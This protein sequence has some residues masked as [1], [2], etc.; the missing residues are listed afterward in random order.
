MNT[1]FDNAAEWITA[2]H[3]K[4]RISDM[5]TTHILNTLRM[6]ICKPHI[7]MTM[8]ITDIEKSVDN[9]ALETWHPYAKQ[10]KNCKK[11]SI[12][13]VTSMLPEEIMAYV[14]DSPLGKAMLAELNTR[15]VNIDNMISVWIKEAAECIS[16]APQKQKR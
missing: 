1:R 3:R 11:K 16:T 13:N 14:I 10:R 9:S 7:T 2:D 6:L 5:E 8:L 4:L 12:S 15:G